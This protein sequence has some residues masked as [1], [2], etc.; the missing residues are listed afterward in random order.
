MDLVPGKV[1]Y[2]VAGTDVAEE[3]GVGDV[4]V[5]TA[6][7][8]GVDD[9]QGNVDTFTWREVDRGD[10]FDP[11]NGY[12]ITVEGIAHFAIDSRR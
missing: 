3:V 9:F 6:V 8:V 5:E 11:A 1:G 2:R 12:R 7:D 4:G 10:H